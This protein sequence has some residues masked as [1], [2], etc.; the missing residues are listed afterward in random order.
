MLRIDPDD[1]SATVEQLRRCGSGRECV[2]YWCAAIGAPD[3]VPKVVHPVHVSTPSYYEVDD[4]WLSRFWVSL[5]ESGL[6][7]SAQV[8]THRGD[9]FHSPTDDAWPMVHT[10]GFLSLVIPRFARHPLSSDTMYL[11]ELVDGRW[12]SRPPRS[13]IDGLP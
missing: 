1:W 10:D 3:V 11:A 8:H 9:A 2:A 5:H 12:L 13:R 7:V 4:A 6:M